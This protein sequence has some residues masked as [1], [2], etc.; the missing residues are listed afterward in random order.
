MAGGGDVGDDAAWLGGVQDDGVGRFH[1]SD[2]AG[3]IDGLDLEEE[4][5]AG[6]AGKAQRC[7]PSFFR[8]PAMSFQ[9]PSARVR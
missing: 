3:L 2:V 8:P 4:L 5:W 6:P 9:G 7:T 1:A